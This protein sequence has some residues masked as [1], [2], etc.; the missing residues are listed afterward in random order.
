MNFLSYCK[1]H[2]I[3][4]AV[5]PPY[6]THTLQPL[7]VV[8]FK[9]LSTAYSIALTAH[10]QRGLGLSSVKKGDFFTLFWEAWIAS[11][12]K[13]LILES[14]SATGIWPMDRDPIMQ[15]FVSK[16]PNT[17]EP[18]TPL[19]DNDDW[20]GME[21]LVRSNVTDINTNGARQLSQTVHHLQTQNEG[22]KQ[23]LTAHKK[24]KKK[25]K[26]LDLQQRKEYRGGTVFWSPRK[27]REARA[28]KLVKQQDEKAQ[29]LG[30]S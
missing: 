22:L 14:F 8:L 28:R 4:L 21:R 17:V 11:V 2:H 29:K 12:T 6:S 3:L 20:R 27:I 24:H 26:Q 9:P 15:R 1:K 13:K 25:G 10:I 23:A 19:I 7:D 5:M 18:S 30:K 16:A